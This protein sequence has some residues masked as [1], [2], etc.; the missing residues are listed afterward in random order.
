L[1]DNVIAFTQKKYG[2]DY[3]REE[4]E[5]RGAE[6]LDFFLCDSQQALAWLTTKGVLYTEFNE[7]SGK[8]VHSWLE[9]NEGSGLWYEW[10]GDDDDR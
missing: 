9:I 3:H 4:M 1:T 10:R 6:Y 2:V 5:R 8:F 7:A